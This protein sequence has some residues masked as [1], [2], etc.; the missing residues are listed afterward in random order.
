[1]K[2]F[3]ED[4]KEVSKDND[5]IKTGMKLN[6]S[7][8]KTYNLIVRGDINKD[9]KV[10]LTDISKLILHYNESKAF[11]LKD[12][13]SLKACDMNFDGEITL[14]DISQL[15]IFYNHI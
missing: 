2:I 12:P 10:T 6:L 1:M 8:G 4:D 9:G 14:T 5:L 3:T 15:I 13:Y 7:N 11:I